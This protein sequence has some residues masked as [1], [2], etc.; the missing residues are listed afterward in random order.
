MEIFLSK[1]KI[2]LHQEKPKFNFFSVKQHLEITK[3]T[4]F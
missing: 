3:E 2:T 4:V 1:I